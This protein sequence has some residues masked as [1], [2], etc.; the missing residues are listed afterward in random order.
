MRGMRRAQAYEFQHAAPP[1]VRRDAAREALL[2]ERIASH[3]RAS[4]HPP[5]GSASGARGCM[6][7][8]GAW[9]TP[10]QTQIHCCNVCIKR[11]HQASMPIQACI[12]RDF[13]GMTDRGSAPCILSTQL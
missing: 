4:P 10:N 5:S 6:H 8:C 12:H 3:P 1:P 11:V 2:Q 9:D 7:A 13:A